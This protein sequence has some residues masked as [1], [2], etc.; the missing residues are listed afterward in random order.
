MSGGALST[1][2]SDDHGGRTFGFGR[3][4]AFVAAAVLALAVAAVVVLALKPGGGA[5]TIDIHGRNLP[6]TKKFGHPAKWLKIPTAPAV[7]IATATPR[8]PQLRAM[9][10]YPVLA[11]LPTGSV[12][13]SVE[14][15]TVP[16]WASQEAGAGK[17]PGDAAVPSA[18]DVTFK[19]AKGSIPLSVSDFDVVTYN[20]ELLHPKIATASGASLPASIPEGRSL[21][22][23]LTTSVPQGDGEVRWAPGGKRILV[24]YFWTLELD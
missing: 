19:A 4:W 3:R 12:Q 1:T 11:K 5:G 22:L 8:T 14:G 10:G 16:N 9:Q 2:P 6:L 15:P 18:F 17:W 23:K 13:I 20:G 7:T 21:T 24:A